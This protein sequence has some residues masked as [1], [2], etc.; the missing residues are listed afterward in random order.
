M[1]VTRLVLTD[2]RNHRDAVVT[3]G[4]GFVVLTGENGA[5]K[6]NILEAV[7]LL[8]PGR[9]LRRASLAE[10]VR[11]G[12]PGGFG[13]AALL[14][15][16]EIGTGIQPDAPQRRLVRINGAGAAAATLAEW[17]TIL[18]LTPAMDRLFVEGPGERRRFLDRLKRR[19]DH[20]EVRRDYRTDTTGTTG[21]RTDND[22][23]L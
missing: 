19:D 10:M 3:A 21:T 22:T 11:Q 20:H 18:W 7:S 17:T 5:G 1:A 2:F 4:T 8:T 16:V 12:A 23:R 14:G 15:D 6:T 13:V 9:G